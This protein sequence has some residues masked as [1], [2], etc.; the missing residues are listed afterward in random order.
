MFSTTHVWRINLCLWETLC[1]HVASFFEQVLHNFNSCL[2]DHLAH[3]NS[4]HE[5]NVCFHHVFFLMHDGT[6]QLAT[7]R[8]LVTSNSA[9]VP[10]WSSM[11]KHESDVQSSLRK[12]PLDMKMWPSDPSLQPMSLLLD[13]PMTNPVIVKWN[14]ADCCCHNLNDAIANLDA[15][16]D[17]FQMQDFMNRI[18]P[19][20]ICSHLTKNSSPSFHCQP[21]L[22]SVCGSKTSF[23]FS[24]LKSWQSKERWTKMEFEQKENETE[25]RWSNSFLKTVL[26]RKW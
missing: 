15:C 2:A 8:V 16:M 6:V 23:S 19:L 12:T 1:S 11:P 18:R 9:S 10:L 5:Q 7:G 20:K 25:D 17:F 3:W 26:M 24:K 4:K 14:S 22:C 13:I 21:Q